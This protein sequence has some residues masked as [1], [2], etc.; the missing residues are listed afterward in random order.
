MACAPRLGLILCECFGIF[1]EFRHIDKKETRLF[2][3]GSCMMF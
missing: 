3:G 1:V 2:G